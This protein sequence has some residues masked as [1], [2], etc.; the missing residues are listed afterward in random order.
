M[1]DGQAVLG[2]IEGLAELF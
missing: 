1:K 2:P